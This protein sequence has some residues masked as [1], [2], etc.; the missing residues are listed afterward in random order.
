MEENAQ[1]TKLKGKIPYD[2]DKFGTQKEYEAKLSSLLEDSEN[3]ALSTLYPFLDDFEGIKL[4]KKYYNWQIRACLE[5][6]NWKNNTGVKSYSEAGL[7]WSK[8]ND[9]PLSTALM[10]ELE[11]P[12]V[13]IPKRRETIDNQ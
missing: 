11:P 12:S 3:I 9:G 5:L 13:G 10:D 8:D 2:V 7:S 6:N 1:L 4:P